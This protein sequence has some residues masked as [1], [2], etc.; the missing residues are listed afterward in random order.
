ML[1]WDIQY[2][3]KGEIQSNLMIRNKVTFAAFLNWINLEV[4]VINTVFVIQGL[5]KHS[6]MK[7]NRKLCRYLLSGRKI[8]HRTY[9]RND[10][11]L[12]LLLFAHHGIGFTSSCLTISKYA[13]VVALKGMLQHFL[14]NIIIHTV[15]WC[16]AGVI[17]LWVRQRNDLKCNNITLF[18]FKWMLHAKC[19]LLSVITLD[20]NRWNIQTHRRVWPV[21]I[22]KTESFRWFLWGFG[23]DNSCRRRIKSLMERIGI[24]FNLSGS[25]YIT[26]GLIRGSFFL[27]LT[28]KE[29]HFWLFLHFVWFI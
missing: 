13:D 3:D 20:W 1:T 26:L 5:F 7:A 2:E 11:F 23:I 12:S 9:H 25:L 4:V 21:G 29:T 28:L 24:W 14:A 15:L 6:M 10:A 17:R 16:K 27:L 8:Y 19:A 18:N 22:I